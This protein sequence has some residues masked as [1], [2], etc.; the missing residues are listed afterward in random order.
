MVLPGVPFDEADAGVVS[1]G[2]SGVFCWV[3]TVSRSSA[4]LESARTRRRTTGLG[5]R[6]SGARTRG[7][8]TV[9]NG[10]R[11]DRDEGS[12]LVQRNFPGA[13]RRV[14]RTGHP[15]DLYV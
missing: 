1:D 12:I 7:L 6:D 8:V 3:V 9:T 11:P 5:A 14:R 15:G 10:T 2:E 4:E 13:D